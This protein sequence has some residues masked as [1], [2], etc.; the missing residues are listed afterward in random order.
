MNG[1]GFPIDTL[2]KND[3]SYTDTAVQQNTLYEYLIEAVDSTGLTSPAVVPVQAR[4]YDTGV[5]PSVESLT[6]RYD[7]KEK[8]V[9]LHW[10]YH[11]RKQENYFF[12]IYRAA[13]GGSLAKYR[14]IGS[15]QTSFFDA[16]LVGSGTYWYSVQVVTENGSASRVSDKVQVAIPGK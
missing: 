14:S 10:S 15:A 8:R 9:A 5:R 12:I 11:P 16:D 13:R 2:L 1:S 4:P 7:E 3:R 6:A